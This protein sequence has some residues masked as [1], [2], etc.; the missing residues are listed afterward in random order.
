MSQRVA[1]IFGVASQDGSYLAD[2]VLAKGYRVVGVLRR[3]SDPTRVNTRHLEGKIEFEYSDHSDFASI[4]AIVSAVQPDEIYNMAAQSVP[5]D[6]W[7]RV[8]ETGDITGL[9]AVRVM[10]AARRH[11]PQARVYQ[12]SSREVFG[13]VHVEVADEK[14]PLHANNPYGVA[15]VYAH[16]M[17][18]VYRDSYDMFACGGILFN[19]ESPRRG[20]HFV[21]R[22]ITMA[23]ACIALRHPS[24]PLD[25]LG[26]PLVVNGR[27]R[28][29]NLQATRD[30]GYA[31]E[32]VEAMWLMLQQD[33][34]RDFVIATNTIHSVAD[35]A[36]AAFEVAGL[37]WRKHVDEDQHLH[38]P[39]EIAD[40][41]GDYSLAKRELGWAPRTFTAD[42][43][44]I[45]VEADIASLSAGENRIASADSPR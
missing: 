21:T 2:L 6:S 44:R 45:M 43:A 15:K 5:A 22:K 16:Q 25:E 36:A 19:H 10:E 32:Y 7:K 39:T 40:T 17:I 12:A 26:R 42:L 1:L 34:P 8:L 13:G 4:A 3:R 31:P 9:G 33:A 35:F 41:R 11:A 30:W 28:L 14:T 20:I 37:D 23:A 27:I 18:G 38:R 29:G 24:P